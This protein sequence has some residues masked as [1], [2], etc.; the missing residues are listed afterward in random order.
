VVTHLAGGFALVP[1]GRGRLLVAGAYV[2]PPRQPSQ[3]NAAANFPPGRSKPRASIHHN[4][5]LKGE[6]MKTV[7]IRKAKAYL[8]E[9]VRDAAA[10]ECST[11]TDNRK[12]VAMI[13]PY[14]VPAVVAESSPPPIEETKLLSDAAA[15]RKA[16]FDVPYPLELDF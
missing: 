13:V 1:P 12:P 3:H 6:P 15:F 14:S 16:L 9:L 2:A 8:S 5:D 11:V 4:F 7:G 10:G